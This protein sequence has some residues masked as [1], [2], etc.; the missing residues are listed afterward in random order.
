MAMFRT[1]LL[2]AVTAVLLHGADARRKLWQLD[3]AQ[4]V[5][6]RKDLSAVVWGISFS[7]D[8]S[9][10]AI[11]FGPFPER[12]AAAQHIVSLMNHI[13][14]TFAWTPSGTALVVG[15]ALAR[16]V[17]LTIGGDP[18]CTFPDLA[19]FRGFLSDDRMVITIN[20]AEIRILRRD[21]S[22][23]DSWKTAGDTRVRDTSPDMDLI[24]TL[25]PSVD[26]SST[27]ELVSGTRE[28]IQRW[29]RNAEET[30]SASMGGLHF[31][32]RGR[33][34]CSGYGS[35]KQPY[36]G[37]NVGCWDTQSGAITARNTNVTVWGGDSI[38]SSC[39]GLLAITDYDITI[40]TGR[41]WHV[42]D[43]GGETVT[44]R[45]RVIWDARTG[46]E[47]ASWTRPTIKPYSAVALSQNGKYYAEGDS[48]SLSV[49]S[50]QP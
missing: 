35:S 8:E 30:L 28:V 50:L 33:M 45:R 20:D 25:S 23:L 18:S 34:L 12:A 15:D 11:G 40:R 7:P 1:W 6:G 42:L 9:K 49:Y 29:S 48:G 46:K 21:C 22:L 38:R 24:A 47:I 4:F 41:L 36:R 19:Q 5:N 17:M 10:L 31:A 27:I 13:V 43:M 14:T 44:P 39:G 16:P 26:G 3:L 2:I 32:D 37:A